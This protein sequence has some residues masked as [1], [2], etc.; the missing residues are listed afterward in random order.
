MI[1]SLNLNSLNSLVESGPVSRSALADALQLSTEELDAATRG[2]FSLNESQINF[3]AEV[4]GVNPYAL[5]ADEKFSP[6]PALV[7]F[8]SAKP[9]P[10]KLS[11][12]GAKALRDV[13]RFL[14]TAQL[15]GATKPNV[16]KLP[17]DTKE[18]GELVRADL[19]LTDT[20]Q[21]TLKD[22]RSLFLHLR[23]AI[24]R[25]NIF[26][27]GVQAE[28]SDFRGLAVVDHN[29]WAIAF[30]QADE[31]HGARSFTLVHEYAHVCNGHAGV[32]DPFLTNNAEERFCN[33]VA[34]FAL[35]PGRLLRAIR[36]KNPHP[37][38]NIVLFVGYFANQ[39]G[40]S[41]YMMAI[42]L[43]HCNIINREE[44]NRWRSQYSFIHSSFEPKDGGGAGSPPERDE[45]KHKVA[46]YGALLPVL[47]KKALERKAMHPNDISKYIGIKKQH[48][49]ATFSEA[50]SRF[51]L[52]N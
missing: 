47:L 48:Q 29:V 18:A 49:D 6:E 40:T 52:M 11:V 39:L 44:F 27:F 12:K 16:R 20:L 22:R 35:A 8:R 50:A 41:K 30:N 23:N 13:K 46:K 1:E 28:R 51:D 19:G 32:S 15:I 43:R 36:P 24:E 4:N 38:S 14:R 33:A 37:Q 42:Q 34:A 31:N 25:R 10:A 21:L 5:F 9:G 26:V 2:L 7:D 3:I 17:S 45:G